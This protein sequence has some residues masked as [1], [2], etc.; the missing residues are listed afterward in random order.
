M[1]KVESICVR[2]KN[3]TDNGGFTDKDIEK[4]QEELHAID[5]QWV[6]GAI[7]EADGSIAAG[8]AE[9]SD[10]INEAHEMISDL[11]DQLPEN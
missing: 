7:K 2:L 1:T 11:L 3:F 8:Q 6:D 4:L 10:L 9:L 5:E